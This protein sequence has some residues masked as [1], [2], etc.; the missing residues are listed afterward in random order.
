MG[1]S[2]ASKEILFCIPPLLMP[3][4]TYPFTPFPFC[5]PR[6][7][8]PVIAKMAV[9]VELQKVCHEVL[10]VVERVRAHGM[11]RHKHTLP[12]GQVIKYFFKGLFQLSLGAFY[13]T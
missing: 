4:Y 11:T 6:N 12:G 9:S 7:Y 3:D 10:N 8:G 13:L 2:K 1:T 5:K